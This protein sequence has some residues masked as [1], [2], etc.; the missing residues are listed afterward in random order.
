MKSD[1]LEKVKKQLEN[2]KT[3]GEKT[4][5]QLPDEKLF[6]RYNE[7]SNSIAAI[8][9]HLSGNMLS[10]WKDFPSRDGKTTWGNREPELIYDI[11]SRKE[12]LEKWNEGWRCLF[13][14]IEELTE[15]DMLRIIYIRNQEHT[16]TDGINIQLTHYSYYIGQIVFI[17]KMI[18]DNGTTSLSNQT[19]VSQKTSAAKYLNPEHQEQSAEEYLR[20]ERN[21]F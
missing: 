15:V 10:R 12:L 20:E 9:K 21:K 5:A 13:K 18:S 16:V 2:Y 4:F 6:W 17:G 11:Q 1:Y 19:G 14:S 8:V 7:N 3:I